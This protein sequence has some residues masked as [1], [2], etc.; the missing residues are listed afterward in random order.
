PIEF[1]IPL[2]VSAT[3]GGAL[4]GQGSWKVLFVTSAPST[5]RSKLVSYS[6][7]YAKVPD[8]GMTGF[9]IVKPPTLTAR[10]GEPKAVSCRAIVAEEIRPW[11]IAPTARGDRISD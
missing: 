10:L 6:P 11:G 3:R 1:N 4:P 8:P 5:P 2:A 9:C 7:L